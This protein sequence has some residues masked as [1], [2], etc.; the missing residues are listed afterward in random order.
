[1]DIT[2]IGCTEKKEDD[3]K[4]PTVQKFR[5]G[6]VFFV[7]EQPWITGQ[8]INGSSHIMAKTRPYVVVTGD[9]ILK[10]NPNI[11]QMVPIT[12]SVDLFKTDDII[13]KDVS[14]K[15]ERVVTSQIFTVDA[16]DI[17]QYMYHLNDEIILDIDRKIA[18]G[19]GLGDSI[20]KMALEVSAVERKIKQVKKS[21]VEF[22]EDYSK[23][24]YKGKEVKTP[25]SETNDVAAPSIAEVTPKVTQVVTSSPAP[26]ENTHVAE[27]DTS[28]EPEKTKKPS[29]RPRVEATWD[30]A[31]KTEFMKD[32]NSK[33]LNYDEIAEMYRIGRSTIPKLYNRLLR[34]C[35]T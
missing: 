28:T 13:F 29:G 16:A 3:R 1:M 4:Y 22:M 34:E 21:A 18:T 20:V 6:D 9:G 11:I 35:C 14:G 27:Q 15:Y 31:A 19:L 7:Y 26:V 8:K 2:K 30:I 25:E 5:K 17:R 33:E 23:D 24:I 10:T 32:Y 12:S